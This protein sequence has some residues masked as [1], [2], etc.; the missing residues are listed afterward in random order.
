MLNS[1]VITSLFTQELED[2]TSIVTKNTL[3]HHLNRLQMEHFARSRGQRIYI[4]PA[5]HSRTKSTSLSMVHAEELLRLPDKG[6]DIP[7]PGLFFYTPQ[8]AT[9]V[10]TNSC[11][12]LGLVNG[13]RGIA[14]GVVV[15]PTGTFFQLIRCRLFTQL[16]IPTI[17]DF[18]YL[19]CTKP[20]VSVLF[21]RQKVKH[22]KFDDLDPKSIP[23]F[24]LE[25]SI[26]VKKFSIRRKQVPM[27]PAFSLT[28]YKV[29]GSSF[30]S[31][32][33]DLHDDSSVKGKDGHHKFT[34]RYVQL[35]RLRSQCGVHL[36]RKISIE[37]LQFRPDDRLL[38][39]MERL[40]NLERSTI[41]AWTRL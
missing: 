27:C 34:S 40:Q 12:P 3:R 19:L 18:F 23:V 11:T 39:E 30:S 2:A 32:V 38:A 24:P 37:D 20:P 8:M 6:A 36:L 29:Q 4:F 13:A 5:L 31:A 15:D 14:T 22:S 10:L 28:D 1:K 26:T 17:A 33:L 9:M 16:T 25:K 21:Q 41:A 35:S 7:F